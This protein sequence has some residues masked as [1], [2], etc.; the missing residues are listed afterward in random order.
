MIKEND[1]LVA[2]INNPGFTADDFRDVAGMTLD[3]TQL[4]SAD[5]YLKSDFIRENKLFTNERGEFNEQKFRDFYKQKT[6]EF[7]SFATDASVDNYEYGL[8]D[9]TRPA[10]GRVRDSGFKFIKVSN[11]DFHSIGITGPNQYQESGLSVREIAQM[12]KIAGRDY[13]VND[14]SLVNSPIKYIKSLFQDPLVLATYDE[15]TT[16]INPI[17]G[18][19]E[20]HPKGSP[21]LNSD[22]QYFYEELGGRSTI[23]K[24]VLSAFDYLTVDQQG[25]NAIDFMDSDDKSKSMGGQIMKSIV[26][27]VPMAFGNKARLIYGGILAVKELA[28]AAPMLTNMVESA[29]HLF[30]SSQPEESTLA[31]TIAG[32]GTKF[33]TSSDDYTQQNPISF[34]MITNLV[35]DVATQWG[36][37]R[38]I[39]KAYVNLTGGAKKMEA[40][41]LA[42]AEGE[43]RKQETL[44]KQ[45]R[46]L[47]KISEQEFL[48]QVG[49][50]TWKESNLGQR[51][52]QQEMAPIQSALANR[53]RIGGDLS[54]AHMAIISNTDMYETALEHGA[55]KKEAAALSLGSIAGMFSVDKFL[56]LGE[57]FL[58]KPEKAAANALRQSV[59]Q[60]SEGFVDGL[61]QLAKMPE[62]PQKYVNIM[63]KGS[64]F[65][66]NIAKKYV[67]NYKAGTLG[68]VGKAFGEGLEETA[69]ELVTDLVKT[70]GELAGDFGLMSQSDLGAWDNM[71]LR[72]GMSFVGGFVGGGIF[73]AMDVIN[74]PSNYQKQE[75]E[76]IIT[77]LRNGKKDEIN[78]II[79][80]LEDEGKFASTTLSYRTTEDGSTFLTAQ[81]KEDSQNHY[82]AQRMRE[83]VTQVDDML[84]Q[85]DLKK[86]DDDLFRSLVLNEQNYVRLKKFLQND[87][88]STGYQAEYN[89]IVKGVL[90]TEIAIKQLQG[91]QIDSKKSSDPEYQKKLDTLQKKRDELLQ[92]K[93]DFLSGK[94]SFKYM[95]K[96]MFAINPNISQPW[97][98]SNFDS[99]VYN[100][101]FKDVTELSEV[102]LNNL[103]QEY[104]AYKQLSRNLE[105]DKAYEIFSELQNKTSPTLKEFNN[106]DVNAISK[107]QQEY[108]DLLVRVQGIRNQQSE[109]IKIP[110]FEKNGTPTADLNQFG[111]TTSN[112]VTVVDGVHHATLADGTKVDQ[113]SKQIYITGQEQKGYFELVKDQ[114]DG[115]YAVHFKPT[116]KNNPKAF[117][118][119]EKDILFKAAAEI[120][121]EGAKLSTWGELSKGG[122]HGLERFRNLGFTQVGTRDVKTKQ[123][124]D[125]QKSDLETKEIQQF[126]DKMV[127]HGK[128]DLATYRMLRTI[129]AETADTIKQRHSL[130]LLNSLQSNLNTTQINSDTALKLQQLFNSTIT[131]DNTTPESI[132]KIL[133]EDASFDSFLDSHVVDF[134]L[135]N[136]QD[137]YILENGG[138]LKTGFNTVQEVARAIEYNLTSIPDEKLSSFRTKRHTAEYLLNNISKRSSRIRAATVLYQAYNILKSNNNIDQ[139]FLQNQLDYLISTIQNEY[140]IADETETANFLA[141][142]EGSKFITT[143]FR[144]F[145]KEAFVTGNDNHISKISN[146]LDILRDLSIYGIDVITNFQSSFDNYLND[147]QVK[148]LNQLDQERDNSANPTYKFLNQILEEVGI[149]AQ[150]TLNDLFNRLF[151][152]N[153][154]DFVI[155]DQRDLDNLQK[156]LDGIKIAQTILI[157]AYSG[158]NASLNRIAKKNNISNIDL[159]E[160]SPEQA[161]IILNN[162]RNLQVEIEYYKAIS[163]SN[164]ANIALNFLKS[165]VNFTKARLQI[166]KELKAPNGPLVI[167]GI[168]LLEGIDD[169]VDQDEFVKLF[170]TEQLFYD[171]VSKALADGSITIDDLYK[172]L[173]S[174]I[175]YKDAREQISSKLTRNINYGSLTAYDKFRYIT[176]VLAVNP[177]DFYNNL[178]QFVQTNGDTIVPIPAQ[179][180]GARVANAMI[181][182]P[183]FV[184]TALGYL[185]NKNNF[186]LTNTTVLTGIAGS[187]KTTAESRLALG[188]KTLVV[189][190]PTSQQS[191]QLKEIFSNAEEQSIQT[192]METI[193]GKELYQKVSD[194]QTQKDY[195]STVTAVD[196]NSSISLKTDKIT[197]QSN[198]FSS[199]DAIVIDEATH[200][201]LADIQILSYWTTK[202]GKQLILIGD[203]AQSQ[204]QNKSIDRELSVQWIAPEL[205]ISLRSDKYSKY[206]NQ[207]DLIRI[208]EKLINSSAQTENANNQEAIKA[209]KNIR[210]KYSN[211]NGFSGDLLSAEIPTDVLENIKRDVD[212]TDPAK[213]NR[214]AFIGSKDSATYKQLQDAGI[215]IDFQTDDIKGIQGREFDYV[216]STIDFSTATTTKAINTLKFTKDLYTIISRSRK[217]S[218]VIDRGISNIIGKSQELGQDSDIKSIMRYKD[219][220]LQYIQ[221]QLNSIKQYM[222][223]SPTTPL[224][225][226]SVALSPTAPTSPTPTSPVTPTSPTPSTPSPTSPA[227]SPSPTP[228]SPT[229]PTPTPTSPA[230]GISINPP[231]TS[232]V[233]TTP[234]SPTPTGPSMEEQDIENN[235]NSIPDRKTQ[236]EQEQETKSTEEE[237][238]KNNTRQQSTFDNQKIQVRAYGNITLVGARIQTDLIEVDGKTKEQNTWLAPDKD[239]QELNDAEIFMGNDNA[240]TGEQKNEIIK[241]LLHIKSIIL[242]PNLSKTTLSS[243]KKLDGVAQAIG[244][245]SLRQI[246]QGNG[247]KFYIRVT[248]KGSQKL[249]GMTNL[250]NDLLNI[251]GEYV[252][253]VVAK[254]S[255]EN[256]KTAC[257]TLGALA[258]PKTWEKAITD[259]DTE[260]NNYQQWLAQA[261][262]EAEYEINSP[263]FMEYTNIITKKPNGDT[264]QY[265]KL[266]SFPEVPKSEFEIR[267]QYSVVSPVYMSLERGKK[268]NKAYVYVSNYSLYDGDQ[269]AQIYHYEREQDAKGNPVPY[270]VR[271][272]YLDNSGIAFRTLT[273]ES[274]KQWYTIQGR[275][276]EYFP[277]EKTSVG[278]E[279]F[280]AIWNHRADLIRFLE[281]M[282][283]DKE[284]A[285]NID[286]EAA[287]SDKDSD[288]SILLSGLRHLQQQYYE[289]SNQLSK[290]SEEQGNRRAT[291]E[292]FKQY[293][294]DTGQQDLIQEIDSLNEQLSKT[295]CR[296]RLG[297]SKSGAYIGKDNWNQDNKD[298]CIFINPVTAIEQLQMLNKLDEKVLDRLLDLSSL[299]GHED[300]IIEINK[301][302]GWVNVFNKKS[303]VTIKIPGQK[304]ATSLKESLG[305]SKLPYILQS[306][307]IAEH[308]AM[309]NAEQAASSEYYI[310]VGKDKTKLLSINEFLEPLPYKIESGVSYDG[311]SG[312]EVPQNYPG[313]II[314]GENHILLQTRVDNMW[315]LIFH[316]AILGSRFNTFENSRHARYEKAPFKYGIFSSPIKGKREKGTEILTASPPQMFRANAFPAFPL[317]VVDLSRKQQDDTPSVQQNE[318]IQQQPESEVLQ[319]EDAYDSIDTIESLSE[320]RLEHNGNIMTVIEAIAASFSDEWGK[321]VSYEYRND[322]VYLLFENN[323]SAQLTHEQGEMWNYNNSSYRLLDPN[324]RIPFKINANNNSIQNQADVIN[325]ISTKEGLIE[326]I[327]LQSILKEIPDVEEVLD[328]YGGRAITNK[329]TLI[330]IITDLQELLENDR[331]D[332]FY[333]K[334]DNIYKEL[335]NQCSI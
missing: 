199:V 72:Y 297:Y 305:I 291:Y 232:N 224:S 130:Q 96:L 140:N 212:N 215:P 12:S 223:L 42:K 319:P 136:G 162:L 73:G 32:F 241:K 284:T 88:Y 230:P 283:V 153:Y 236:E 300:E 133:A 23:G 301:S 66:K 129:I 219:V 99:F 276:L 55:T 243:N 238:A 157:S 3:N 195:F 290:S 139:N 260:L 206:K 49:T 231:T 154:E 64:D 127:Q 331:Y 89:K 261:T 86:T 40:A 196:D 289:F 78:K 258:D 77:Y 275:S 324:N 145:F 110:V 132:R 310:R 142:S 272:I 50:S 144:S 146:G 164:L 227:V 75:F 74:N 10:D 302:K 205:G 268:S 15:D 250:D 226:G 116:D 148:L 160:L 229:A 318:E 125:Q 217:G 281:A 169:I 159:A 237:N 165:D 313:I 204:S 131:L 138:N 11:P 19:Q 151:S 37:Q 248:K 235:I 286:L 207:T 307:S 85:N 265:S 194:P 315:D 20:F 61:K 87:S 271:K 175:N 334:L 296:F 184:N 266:A 119:Q 211:K 51:L 147:S 263:Q 277:F 298:N 106:I 63:K 192:I 210:L 48:N 174:Y 326:E 152:G 273:Q 306:L 188:N 150:E 299:R 245:N 280:Q 234:T 328:Q 303:A 173:E 95:S 35:T 209:L 60:E 256:G 253:T 149:D 193:L 81:S 68:I 134:R 111:T 52:I 123:L 29:Y 38:A 274:Y 7:Q 22:G 13:S 158:H 176:T 262:E 185:Q 126:V 91:E 21:R 170:R 155:E 103:K 102:E 259:D 294:I 112:Q 278:I 84:N 156:I 323:V 14:M 109:D 269:L 240:H 242:Y 115:Q 67:E 59:A 333:N 288:L 251:N 25:L 200:I 69:E 292:E 220:F 4:L 186:I 322:S 285:S 187:G 54:L 137:L 190:G 83:L 143:Q 17:T 167:N 44:L 233:P 26:E 279:M 120:L 314:A 270:T 122:I 97:Y 317:M 94:E 107:L 189:S 177:S 182:N 18:I 31:N 93:E 34:G 295:N 181:T 178:D 293:L 208:S 117:T 121:P 239:Q 198:A 335:D 71:L 45:Q 325:R 222:N 33:S 2:T 216:I 46:N 316:G 6:Q 221:D 58:E 105:L 191:Q 311:V 180:F 62:S 244:K 249:A 282:G 320:I 321:L 183:N 98:S 5:E 41:A 79:T 80:Q 308:F 141:D 57:M 24:Q 257:V 267:T 312:I 228:T 108:S 8:Q 332:R 163:E 171:N 255:M 124:T 304:R 225:G 16:E 135:E 246:M 47:N 30:D 172:S 118:N 201:S 53:Y 27:L 213:K 218:V 254:F 161:N 43:F 28:K 309:G 166:F 70:A 264:V 252:Y 113:P 202:N 65:G 56:G 329:Q 168:N 104:E 101:T 247:I 128:I 9:T 1:W 39:Q 76:N 203:Q 214:L 330:T 100:K 197:L 90:D 327:G 179:I 82:V 287:V 92:R 114:E 36:Q